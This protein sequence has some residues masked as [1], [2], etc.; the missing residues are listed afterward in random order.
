M[1]V[2][3]TVFPY[4]LF[5]FG[6]PNIYTEGIVS[7]AGFQNIN[8]LFIE[9]NEADREASRLVF[10]GLMKY[11]KE[12]R[13]IVDDLATL[14]INEE[15][16]E[17][18]FTIRDGIFW[19]DDAPFT[20]DD[21][22]FT[23][24]DVIGSPAFQN[25]I[26]KA[27]LSE[28]K[29][30]K[31]D[32]RTIKFILEKPNTFFIANFTTGILPKHILGNIPIEEILVNE[33]NKKPIGTG[34][35]RMEEPVQSYPDGRMQVVLQQ[36]KKY[37]GPISEIET[38]RLISYP[39]SAQLIAEDNVV[40]GIVKV[41]EEFIDQVKEN[42]RFSLQQYELPQYTAVF[43]N[44]ES[45]ALK[46]KQKV[47]LALQ[48]AIDKE[49]LMSNLPNK[50]A[51]DTPL[52]QLNQ[53]EWLYQ[54]NKTEAEGAL[55]DSGYSYKAEDTDNTGYRYD[56]QGNALE[57]TLIARSYP[58]GTRQLQE[59]TEVIKYLKESWESIGVKINL[60]FLD[61]NT[62]KERIKNRS[63]DMLLVGQS[64][65]YNLDTYS[66]W[67]SSQ[68]SPLGQN[69]SNYKSFRVDSLIED[70]RS[71]LDSERQNEKLLELAAQ[72]QQDI[73]AIFLYRP[74]YYYASDKKVGNLTMNGVVFA[75]DRYSDISNWKFT[76]R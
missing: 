53:D 18:T 37:Y 42:E 48:K 35:Y 51:V 26:L 59:S 72:I 71:T 16:T 56:S 22:Y 34:P 43:F 4:G 58:D 27:N 54:P 61:Q 17:Y 10:S 3:I 60:E 12:K 21:V 25:E 65:G 45:E 30:E 57:F 55:K 6:Q 11:D 32:N 75:S 2:K 62:F 40:N 7:E 1:V 69:L 41:T 24:Q 68:A 8:P 13:N 76:N 19:H 70:I 38:V 49:D 31:T 23:Y 47:R 39:T 50:I 28:V 36:N 66:Y 64:L 29:I 73:P 44:L 74:V 46:D 52:M 5:N 9:Y 15:K 33:F 20:V 63:Y 14:S 67:H